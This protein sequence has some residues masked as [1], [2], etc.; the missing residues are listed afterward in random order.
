MKSPLPI[1]L[2]TALLLLLTA[3]SATER[4]DELSAE[5]QKQYTELPVYESLPLRRLSWQEALEKLHRN[6]LE[7]RELNRQ[8]ENSKYR[9]GKTL[10]SLI[11]QLDAG[12]YYNA[13]L[14]WGHGY[15]AS[16]TFNLN[17]FFN[18][19]QLMYLPVERYTN[20]LAIIKV[21][22][23]RRRKI[24]ELEARLYQAF[25]EHALTEC[26][27][28][29]ELKKPQRIEAESRAAQ[30]ALKEKKRLAWLS[31]C[32]LLNDHSA[33]WV[34]D[35]AG[36]PAIR[37]KD[38]LKRAQ[39]P[40]KLFLSTIALQAEAARLNRLGLLVRFMPTA[41]INF[42]SPSL[43]T[44]SGGELD[45]FM[46]N[47]DDV[48]INFNS[49][50]SLDTRLELWHDY[51]DAKLGEELV[52]EAITQSMKE[53]REKIG[54]T[55]RSWRQYEDWKLGIGDYITFRNSQGVT[56]FEEALKRNEESLEL[57][58]SLISQE[59]SNLERECAAIQ[60]YGWR[61]ETK[62]PVPP[63]PTPEA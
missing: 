27:M 43:F 59:R 51:K 10:R 8:Y 11:P 53:H 20:A 4:V 62:E 22:V 26:E 17:I 15:P 16:S 38:Y 63:P 36:L 25:R 19:P 39:K 23:D 32:T 50:V 58:K 60:E 49:Y 61:D 14:R 56:S 29:L 37:L 46:R 47:A 5:Y 55:L 54:A 41:R 18:L 35:D 42:Y 2:H 44:A 24:R 3:C 48:R 28:R 30:E 9:L 45:G 34:P 13:P 6:N 1:A 33:R 21:D 57:E 52:R 40:D 31:L 12:Y 7:L